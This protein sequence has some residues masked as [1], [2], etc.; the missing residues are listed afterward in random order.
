MEPGTGDTGGR[1]ALTAGPAAPAGPGGPGSPR[2]PW[3]PSEPRTPWGPDS[4]WIRGQ[5]TSEATLDEGRDGHRGPRTGALGSGGPRTEALWASS[6]RASLGWGAGRR[7]AGPRESCWRRTGPHLSTHSSREARRTS[8]ASGT[9]QVRQ[10]RQQVGRWSGG[11]Q[12]GMAEVPGLC[13][14][15]QALGQPHSQGAQQHR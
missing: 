4:P 11:A 1:W 2:A 14:R 12:P 3:G 7:W 15:S 9:L 10:R 13:P 5:D 8:W 6:S